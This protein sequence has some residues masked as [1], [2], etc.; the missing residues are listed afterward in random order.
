MGNN[1]KVALRGLWRKKTFSLIN[2]GGLAIGIA[3]SLL[4]FLFIRYELSFD[5]FHTKRNRIYRVLS[6][7]STSAGTDYTQGVPIPLAGAMR[8]DFPQLAK[9]AAIKSENDLQITIP[10]LNGKPDKKLKEY[11][12]IFYT[13]PAL[14]E[15]FDF[16]WLEGNPATALL[17]PNT[18]ALTQTVADRYFGSWKQAVGKT[19]KV[20]NKTLLTVTGIIKDLPKNTDLPLKVVI[21]YS[22]DPETK[23]PSWDWI[24]SRN[25]C[26]VLL[27]EGQKLASV[28]NQLPAFAKKYYNQDQASK[29]GHT[30][31]ALRDMHFDQRVNVF[32]GNSTSRKQLMTLGLIGLFLLVVACINFVNLATAQAVNRSKE[33]GVRKVLGSNRRQLTWQFLSETALITSCSLLIASILAELTLPWLRDLVGRD[34]SLN[35][36]HY[37]SILLFLVVIGVLV[38]FLAG[39]YPAMVLSG[40]DPIVAIKSKVTAKT[41]GAL[42]LRRVLVVTQFVIAQLLIVGT[43]V[44]VKQMDYFKTRPQGFDRAAIALVELPTDS[45]GKSRLDYFKAEVAR[46]NGVQQTSLCSSPPASGWVWGTSFTYANNPRPEQFDLNMKMADVDYFSTFGIT[47]VAGRKPYPSDTLREIVVNE[48]MVRKLGLKYADDIIGKTITMHARPLAIVGVARDFNSQSLHDA[49]APIAIMTSK[50]SYTKLAIRLDPRQIKP[51]MKQVQA[52]WDKVYP[53]YVYDAHYFDKDIVSFY[54]EE[55]MMSKLFRMFAAIAIF[56]SCLGL[57]GLVSFMAVQRTK[58]VGIRKVLGASVQHIVYLFSREFTILIIVAFVVAGPLSYYFMNKWLS[59]FYYRINISWGIFALAM[60]V[61]I[62]LAWITV[63]YK[64]IRAAMASPVKSLKSE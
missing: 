37:P 13:E 64:A 58:E 48:T 41:V 34:L 44:V 20:D 15:I 61:S 47:L 23:Q 50:R 32:G 51:A 38:T 25:Q 63:G 28:T 54:D 22:T 3:A 9:V 19:I 40:F 53:E 49:L 55:E 2:I 4:I 45:L 52:I 14:F 16:P 59:T 43:L 35:L 7:F 21:S 18:V 56:I 26:Y 57:Y 31:Q 42:S 10:G 17:Q 30:V 36:F 62:L 39:F 11:N 6:D 46:L 29:Q 60:V 8:Q 5:T 27:A 12:G 24:T 33:I 1:L